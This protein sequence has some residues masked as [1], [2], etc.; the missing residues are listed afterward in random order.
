V[1]ENRAQKK[2]ERKRIL[3]NRRRR[4]AHRLRER[5]W[6][7]QDGP[8]LGA[9]NLH[10]ELAEKARGLGCGGIGAMHLLARRTGLIEALDEKLHLLKVHLPYHESDHVLNLAY[11]ILSGGTCI[12]DLELLRQNESYLDALGAQRIP[13]PTTA[14]DFCRRFCAADVET[15]QDTI[16]EVRLKVWKQQPAEFFAEAV[17]DV[18]GHVAGTRGECKE[19]M[20]LSYKGVWGYHPLIVS[21]ANTQ[22]PLYLVNRSGNRPSHEGAAEYIDRAVALCKRAG[23][24]VIWVRGDT[25]FTQ[26]KKLD[27]WDADGVHFLF[28]IDAHKTLIEMAENLPEEW[29]KPLPHEPKYTVKTEPRARPENV[30]ERI[31]V[32]KGYENIKLL[33]EEVAEFDYQPT[34]CQ[35]VYTVIAVRKHLVVEKGQEVLFPQIKYFFYITNDR[36]KS[37][38]ELVER[39]HQR[40]NQEN[41]IEQLKN[42]VHAMGL[43][44]QDLVSNGAYMVMA[45]LAWTLKA[46]FALL[47]PEKGRWAEKHRE[48]KRSVL[49]MEFKGFLN[50]FLRLPCQIVRTGRRIVYRLLSWNPWLE[51]FFRG[52]DA[53]R[54]RVPRGSASAAA[55]SG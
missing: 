47:L 2:A 13:D 18:D 55:W 54:E 25:D 31:V 26:T 24:K 8:M 27:G 20:A 48:Q 36:K 29:W 23:F 5:A 11:N 37:E 52:V 3:R 28:G 6:G 10:Y 35:K 7:P 41:L 22:E 42:G 50:A 34:A 14:G 21:L 30:K 12:Q 38:A 51:V 45:S 46:W 4:I 53:L 17:I 16:N 15:L 33:G 19:G 40:C 32:E 39:A 44:V 49:T 1:S 9:R 43:P